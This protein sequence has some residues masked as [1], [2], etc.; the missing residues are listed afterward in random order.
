MRVCQSQGLTT[1]HAG[2]LRTDTLSLMET[3]LDIFPPLE[4]LVDPSLALEATVGS[5]F[6]PASASYSLSAFPIVGRGWVG[7][8]ATAVG[9]PS[10]SAKERYLAWW[11]GYVVFTGGRA[12][13]TPYGKEKN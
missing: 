4:D 5:A 10:R 13:A 11:N 9:R 3:H 2:A 7:E 6:S 1:T 12:A 8:Q